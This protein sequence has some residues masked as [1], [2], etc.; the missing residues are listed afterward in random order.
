[1]TLFLVQ[2]W[3]R[4]V[5]WNFFWV[6]PRAGHCWLSF[7]IHLS[8]HI[9]IWLRNGLLLLHW[10]REDDISKWWFFGFLVSSWGTHLLSFFTFPVCFKCQVTIEWSML[11]SSATSHVVRGSTSVMVLSWLLT[12]DGWPQHSSSSRLSPPL[13]NPFNHHCTTHSLAFVGQM[14]Y[15]WCELSPLLY[16]PFWNQI[17]KSPEFAFCLS[18][19]WSKI[20]IK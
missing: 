14:H 1:M 3:L 15:W 6:H 9:T 20:H 5:L 17:R 7:K 4:E 8:S 10:I 16:D 11:S 19:P 18:F 13:K 2:I 12:F